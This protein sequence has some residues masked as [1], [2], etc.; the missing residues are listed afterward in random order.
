MNIIL[1]GLSHRTA[2]IAI[3]ERFSISEAQMSEALCRMKADPMIEECFILSTCN[4]AEAVAVVKDTEVG[5]KSL[6]TFWMQE[7]KLPPE[8]IRSALYFYSATDAL[9]HIFRVASSLDSMIVGEPQILGQMKDAF[10][11]AMLHK[12]TGMLLNKMFKKAISVAKRVRTETKISES[13]VS[14]AFAAVELGEKILGGLQKKTAMIIGAGDMA[15]LVARHFVANGVQSLLIANRNFDRALALAKEFNGIP[16]QLEAFIGAIPQCDIV[17]CSVGA[18]NYIIH[19]EEVS[20]AI[21]IRQNRPIFFIDIS[22]PRNIDPKINQLDNVF[23]YDID[24]LQM[25]VASNLENRKQEALKAEEIILDEV[26]RFSKWFKSLEAVPMIIALKDRAEAIRRAEIE[27]I[28]SKL[29]TPV[30]R[31]ILD[32]LTRAIVNKLLHDPLTVLKE[33]SNSANG[34]MMLEAASRLFRLEDAGTSRGTD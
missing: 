16:I 17:L 24:D 15:E 11:L 14:V 19:V 29:N 21:A 13:A 12:A 26:G 5:F 33:E 34:N 9:R 22:V 30:E 25:A 1:V 32:T 2:P 23:L 7:S 20:R 3:R 27:K 10:D 31:E 28:L 8:Q 4:R 6:E 18:P